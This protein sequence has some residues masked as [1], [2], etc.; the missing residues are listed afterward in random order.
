M[1]HHNIFLVQDEVTGLLRSVTILL[2]VSARFPS[3]SFKQGCVVLKMS[4]VTV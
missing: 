3:R 4:V 2:Y 1:A